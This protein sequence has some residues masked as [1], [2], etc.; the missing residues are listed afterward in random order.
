MDTIGQL[1]PSQTLELLRSLNHTPVRK[2]G[3]N[4]LIDSN[5]VRKSLELA[6]VSAGDMIVEVGPGLG[7]LTG[8]LLQ[9]GAN[10]FAVEL[11]RELFGFLTKHFAGEKNLSI[12]NAD[13]LDMPLAKLPEDAA[14]F[15]IVANLPYA[16]STPW[17]DAVLARRLPKA[18]SL[19][20]QKEAAERFAAGGGTG[21]FSPISVFLS[22]AYEVAA[23]HRVSASCF[24]PKPAVDSVLLALR[25]RENPFVFAPRTKEIIRYAFSKRRKQIL[26]ISKSAGEYSAELLRWLETDGGL[27]PTQRPERI[28]AEHWR[29]LDAVV[30]DFGK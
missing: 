14:D 20:L 21:E 6:D 19:M 10:V 27:S 28:D 17:L 8:A 24:Y 18:M 13:A 7:T 22:Q 12:V 16:I 29:R 23:K 30:L 9:A 25:R 5:I 3:Q 4:F 2:L 15:K 11:D 1:S 26:S